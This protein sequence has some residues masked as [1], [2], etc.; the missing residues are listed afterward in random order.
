MPLRDVQCKH[1][2]TERE[3]IITSDI[4]RNEG[5]GGAGD[6][7]RDRQAFW[8]RCNSKSCKGRNRPHFVI[9]RFYPSAIR[10]KDGNSQ[11]ESNEKRAKALREGDY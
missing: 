5:S 10:F 9:E 11:W 3:V 1:C 7:A 6:G 2:L 8:F 4:Y